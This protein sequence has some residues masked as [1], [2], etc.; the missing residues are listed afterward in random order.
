LE[1]EIPNCRE[2]LSKAQQIPSTANTAE[3]NDQ[4]P[5]LLEPTSGGLAP[6]LTGEGGQEVALPSGNRN[7]QYAS[8]VRES[9]PKRYKMTLKARSAIPTEEIN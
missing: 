7:R 3:Q 5:G 6:K 9:K 2:K 1:D 8:V 4:R